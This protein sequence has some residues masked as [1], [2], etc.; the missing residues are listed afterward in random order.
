MF[1]PF[2]FPH[3]RLRPRPCR[4]RATASAR[5]VRALPG[6]VTES[7]RG[8]AQAGFRSLDAPRFCGV[9]DLWPS[10]CTGAAR[11][12]GVRP[13][14]SRSTPNLH[15]AMFNMRTLPSAAACLELTDVEQQ[16][17]AYVAEGLAPKE[18]SPAGR[19]APG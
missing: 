6:W 9:A 17:L 10:E 19:R 2:S 13:E 16:V 3:V 11:R 14:H 8:P 15:G 1:V 18:I 4:T 12:S 5:P 7:Q